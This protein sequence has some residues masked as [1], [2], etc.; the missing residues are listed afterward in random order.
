ME[1]SNILHSLLQKQKTTLFEYLNT[2]ALISY[3][4]S[5]STVENN[6]LSEKE[7]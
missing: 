1:S 7:D 5:W 3:Y 6:L 2:H 4:Q